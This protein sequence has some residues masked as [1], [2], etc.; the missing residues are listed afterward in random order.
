[1]THIED[2]PRNAGSPGDAPPYFGVS[3]VRKVIECFQP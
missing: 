2:R 3:V 1:M